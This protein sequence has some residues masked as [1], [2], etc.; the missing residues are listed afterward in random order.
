MENLKKFDTLLKIKSLLPKKYYNT[1]LFYCKLSEKTFLKVHEKKFDLLIDINKETV[2][3][4]IVTGKGRF[5]E[6]HKFS[7]DYIII[8]VNNFITKNL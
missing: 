5:F 7:F 3:L 4:E 2:F 8:Q 1:D 6:N